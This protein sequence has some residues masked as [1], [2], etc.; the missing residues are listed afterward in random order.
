MDLFAVSG[1][2]DKSNPFVQL[3]WE[4]GTLYEDEVVK[5]L[6]TPFTDLSM[7]A[8][9]E[10]ESE[11]L[12]AIQRGDSLIYSGRIQAD[13][14]LGDPDLLRR[15]GDAYVAG[16]IKSGAG[17]EGAEDLSKP[18]KH[19]A[20]QLGL[21]TDILER[22][23]VS[24]GRY[25]FIWDINGEEVIYDFTNPQ[26]SRNPRKLWQDYEDYLAQAKAIVN[27]TSSTLPAYSGLCKLCHWYSA[28]LSRLTDLDDLTLIPELGRS[29]RDK[30]IE[31]I[32]TT[33]ELADANI[34]EF[35]SGKKTIFPGIGAATLEKFHARAKLLSNGDKAQPYLREPIILPSNDLEL[36]FDIEVDPIRDICYLHGFVER[37]DLNN[38]SER[39]VSFFAEEPTDEAERK[40]FT[41]AWQY[42][43][44]FTTRSRH[45]V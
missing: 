28:C 20:V 44:V 17:S 8:G 30:L 26:S 22:K 9:A 29:K 38:D 25:G 10:K 24:A 21:Y 23:G 12:K 7:Y 31:R 6:K 40:A 15:E 45:P 18:K 42:M 5:G 16:D 13:E 41:G 32:S 3:L 14:L 27:E 19:Y 4:K 33:R 11:T 36:F 35:L 2:R 34:A 39:F 43:P 1:E 37:R